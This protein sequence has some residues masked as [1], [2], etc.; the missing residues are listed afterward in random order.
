MPLNELAD[1]QLKD[2]CER[3]EF[4]HGRKVLAIFK[5]LVAEAGGQVSD[6][7]TLIARARHEYDKRVEELNAVASLHRFNS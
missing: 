6:A 2:L 3:V 4:A 7:S 5:R 1:P